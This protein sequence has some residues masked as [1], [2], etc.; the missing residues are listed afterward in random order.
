MERQGRKNNENIFNA[1]KITLLACPVVCLS[2]CSSVHGVE[3]HLGDG[4]DGDIAENWG[5]CGITAGVGADDDGSDD[6]DAS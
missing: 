2:V 4:S 1:F 6:K 3:G 5:G